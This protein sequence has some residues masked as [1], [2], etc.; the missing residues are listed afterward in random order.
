MKTNLK[1]LS[2]SLL[3]GLFLLT[4]F[5]TMAGNCPGPRTKCNYG[6]I[7]ILTP[8]STQIFISKLQSQKKFFAHHSLYS[9]FVLEI[10]KLAQIESSE[11]RFITLTEILDPNGKYM[12]FEE[13]LNE[14]LSDMGLNNAEITHLTTIL[15]SDNNEQID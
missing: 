1:L 10:E 15:D 11:E 6:S 8:L 7:D 13:A 5:S 9:S 12:S 3:L 14:N 4:S 2:T